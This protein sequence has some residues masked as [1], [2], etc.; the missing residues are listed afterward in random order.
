MATSKNPDPGK[1]SNPN[2][3]PTD[4]GRIEKEALAWSNILKLKGQI[5]KATKEQTALMTVLNKLQGEEAKNSLK[6]KG[7]I[8]SIAMAEKK[9]AQ[10]RATGTKAEAQGFQALIKK[11]KAN[12]EQYSKT[13]GGSIRMQEAA[14]AK[15]KV[16]LETERNLIKSI[17][18]EKKSGLF[19]KTTQKD[20]DT[21][22]LKAGGGTNTG[23]TASSGAAGGT[24]NA[25]VAGAMVA[26]V[27]AGLAGL[28]AIMKGLSS[29]VKSGLTV[30][31]GEAA[32]IVGSKKVGIGGGA[33]SGAGAT[34]I[35]D[36]FG[37]I[38]G[39]IPFIGGALKGLTGVF[40]T[41]LDAV[42]GIDQANMNVARELGISKKE[43]Q[44]FRASMFDAQ[45]ASDNIVVNQTRLVESQIQLSKAL[46]VNNAFS[47]DTLANN[48]KL[49]NIL[50]LE[51]GQTQQIA[52]ASTITGKKATDITKNM[53]GQI[54]YLKQT[55]GLAFKYQDIL[56]EA[57][58]LS[59]VL[60]LQ[61]AKYPAK[62]TQSLLTVKA[63][64]FNLKQINDI[65]EGFLDFESSIS[66][67]MEAQVLTGKD[68]NLT[69]AREAAL[70]NDYA[71]VAKEITKYTG[72][73]AEYLKMNRIEADGLAGAMNMTRD[74]MA[75]VLKQQEI[76]NALGATD[77]KQAIQKFEAVKNN[78][79]QRKQLI[80]SI[81]EENYAELEKVSTAEKLAGVMDR[82][83]TTFIAFLEKSK[84]FEFLTDD[85]KVNGFIKSVING[86]A[87]A[88]DTVGQIIAGIV[89]VIGDFVGFFSE[90]KGA[91]FQGLAATVGGG[92]ATFSG[93]IRSAGGGV[94][95]ALADGGVVQQT[96]MAK[97]DKGEAYL[98]AN[99]ITVLKET[100]DAQKETNKY[101][102]ALLA[103][104]TKIQIDGREIAVANANNA[105]SI[106]QSFTS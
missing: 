26:G 95:P 30:P 43:A 22:R 60:G 55:T 49:T 16:A 99:S 72:T 71:T 92:A 70:N 21:A 14:A 4:V 45:Q 56:G 12:L 23:T 63:L 102:M 75:D 69:K 52:E 88:I 86:L 89:S 62:L 20:I 106:Y 7:A 17:N 68:I 80:T 1:A 32:S 13:V 76:L 47:K 48:V 46:G 59:G 98:G 24:K 34:S 37:D 57:G 93:A 61:F 97:V 53:F 77:M 94:G 73:A 28:G 6:A 74:Q 83:K 9:L 58:K 40:K 90:E 10:A 27:G 11:Q 84:I 8:D 29:A 96:G 19:G 44:G 91:M 50:G 15:Q 42:L 104:D 82:I 18:K 87:G 67:E 3:D 105:P 54:G 31:L 64:G 5:N 25:G 65:S 101:L 2:V 78:G 35:L 39:T 41:I 51:I 100:L 81:G 85:K 103:K 38:L 36:G 33:V 66:K 79:T